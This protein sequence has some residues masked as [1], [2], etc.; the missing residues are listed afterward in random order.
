MTDIVGEID[1][2]LRRLFPLNRSLSGDGNRETL[3]VLSEVVPIALTEVPSGEAVFDWTIPEEWN[4][5]DAWIALPD[6]RRVVDFRQS[7]LH[8]VSYSEPFRGNLDW[9][10]LKP[11][12]HLHPALPE[13]IP[14]RT[15]YY[16]RTWGFCLT[17]S[18]YDVLEAHGGPFEVVVDSELKPGSITYG[19]TLIAGESKQEI[20]VS[21]YICH[22]SMA[23]DSLS[24]VLLTAFLARALRERK[25][26]R[27]SYRVVFV[28]ETIGA[29]AYCAR[30]EAAMKRIDLGLVATT[31]GGP[32]KF[33][34]K[35]SFDPGHPINRMIAEVFAESGVDPIVYPFDIHGSDERQY[36]SQGFRINVATI[37]RDRYYEYPYYH[38]SLDDLSFVSATQIAETLN[39]YLLLIEKFE[40]RRIYLNKL[41]NCEAMLS[42]HGLYPVTGGAQQPAQRSRLELDLILWLL[43]YCDGKK[44]IADIGFLLNESESKLLYVADQ[45]VEKGVL[46]IVA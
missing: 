29:V 31:V 38:S 17:R 3:R 40:A 13:A 42:R 39:L 18:Q 11:H 34:V 22:P 24:G 27:F 2:Y 30:N 10:A 36:S 5:R 16:R 41:P 46:D 33:G 20:L 7:N 4:V 23:N 19:E 12:L 14:Y 37:C 28:P 15:S 45:L 44:S 25:E 35:Q 32:G 6:G 21:C 9:T 8:L 26:R 1:A 43:F